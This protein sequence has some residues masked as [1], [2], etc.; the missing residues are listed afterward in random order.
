MSATSVTPECHPLEDLKESDFP[1]L[2]EYSYSR[3]IKFFKGSAQRKIIKYIQRANQRILFTSSSEIAEELDISQSM[4]KKTFYKLQE[5]G[6]I[7]AGAQSYDRKKR[8]HGQK[9]IFCGPLDEEKER[10]VSPY[11]DTPQGQ[12]LSP[13]KIER[14]LKDKNLSIL[15]TMAEKI[16]S[17]TDEQM[18][19]WYPLL[20]RAGFRSAQIQQIVENLQAR[21]KPLDL[22]PVSLE[23][24]EWELAHGKMVDKEGRA[25]EDPA[26][27]VFSS[28]SLRGCYR[29]PK[30][31]KDELEEALDAEKNRQAKREKLEEEAFQNW[32]DSLSDK[33]KEEYERE[34]TGKAFPEPASIFL[35]AKW[36][37]V[38]GKYGS[39]PE[40]P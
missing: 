34:R 14:S 31:Y 22:I 28:L 24:A 37:E 10:T 8:M 20:A 40:I 16:L 26:S 12:P 23:Y 18:Q 35:R 1:L 27:F 25:V 15:E 19:Q 33:D 21:L 29:R 36:K 17:W 7:L 32:L 30:G 4:V 9:I 39:V 5:A 3:A 2:D 13:S 6:I 11:S 38:A